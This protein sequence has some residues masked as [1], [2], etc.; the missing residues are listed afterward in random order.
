MAEYYGVTRTPDYLAH[1]GVK[2][3]KWGVRRAI[4]RGNA[5]AINRHYQ[6]AKKKLK[7][8]N[9]RADISKQKEKSDRLNKFAKA[10]LKIGIAGMGVAAGSGGFH[11][12]LEKRYNKVHEDFYHP[13]WDREAIEASKL[14]EAGDKNAYDNWARNRGAE[15]QRLEN[16]GNDLVKYG[17]PA[18]DIKRISGGIGA[19]ALGIAGAAKIGAAV[20]KRRATS[21][22]HAKAVAERDAW[23]REMNKTFKNAK[24][25]KLS[26]RDARKLKM[27]NI[28]ADSYRSAIK[29]LKR[30]NEATDIFKKRNNRFI[31]MWNKKLKKHEAKARS[32]NKYLK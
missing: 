10:N 31:K 23:K 4:E 24:V 12:L 21:K 25:S 19:A 30:Q 28:W 16:A 18:L 32:I 6:K 20:T 11:R 27:A 13:G 15:A 14:F 29:D 1:Y 26:K 2:G 5:S 22:G 9:D 8:L 17:N 3:M 7:K